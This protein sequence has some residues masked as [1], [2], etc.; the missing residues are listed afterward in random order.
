MD[1]DEVK[2]GE[3][4]I[5][6]FKIRGEVIDS[7]KQEVTHVEG[8]GGGGDA[9][10]HISSYTTSPHEFWIKRE[11]GQEVSYYLKDSDLPLRTGQ[12]VT[13]ISIGLKGSGTSYAMIVVNHSSG[14]WQFIGYDTTL[15]KIVD[16]KL[17][18][19]LRIIF[20]PFLVITVCMNLLPEDIIDLTLILAALLFLYLFLGRRKGIS[21]N[22]SL[23]EKL[24]EHLEGIANTTLRKA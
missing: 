15:H 2:I 14:S 17:I 4:I 21:Q 22:N 9:P 3:K 11:D 10:V 1:S 6:T 8:G 19:W 20:L 13:I 12:I 7:S 23:V 16:K 24:T 5:E 18:G